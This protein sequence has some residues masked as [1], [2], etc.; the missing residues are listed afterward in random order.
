MESEVRAR[1]HTSGFPKLPRPTYSRTRPY[2]EHPTS[3]NGAPFSFPPGAAA[4]HG[5]ATYSVT[6]GPPRGSRTVRG[7]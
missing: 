6:L 2:Q 7:L 5:I 4:K 3:Q 1:S